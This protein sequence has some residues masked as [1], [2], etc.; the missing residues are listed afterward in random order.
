LLGE[1]ID[2]KA[3]ASWPTKFGTLSDAS[4]GE[5]LTAFWELDPGEEFKKH[6]L[7]EYAVI[8]LSDL[9]AEQ[10]EEALEAWTA[11]KEEQERKEQE[12]LDAFMNPEPGEDGDEPRREFGTKPPGSPIGKPAA[13]NPKQA[14]GGPEKKR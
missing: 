10:L 1:E 7:T 14:Q 6:I 8:S 2:D 11:E 9:T 4:Q 13:A 5:L 12:Q 3:R